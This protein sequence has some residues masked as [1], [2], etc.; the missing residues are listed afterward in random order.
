[1]DTDHVGRGKSAGLATAAYQ[2]RLLTHLA[3]YKRDTLGVPEP[4][5][6]RYR[7]GDVLR[8]HILPT[9]QKWLNILEPRRRLVRDYL[10]AHPRVKLHHYFHHLTS[11]QAFAFNLFI[12]YFEGGSAPARALLSSL[13]QDSPLVSWQAE[14]VPDKKEN[15]NLDAE[16][17]TADGQRTICEVK[18]SERDF[19]KAT[20]DQAHRRKLQDLY[21]PRLRGHVAPELL[22][23]ST[24]FEVYQILRNVWHLVQDER[25]RLV[26][27]LPRGNAALWAQLHS[28]LQGV[29]PPM[30]VP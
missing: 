11:S 26:F 2:A 3:A 27:L 25:T 13:G 29:R 8:D 5:T 6:F 22:A 23:P 15:T 1:M 10:D 28:T 9:T 18:L 17:R 24:F 7:N 16:W 21:E 4:G 30:C 19:G 12:P 14:S 20:D